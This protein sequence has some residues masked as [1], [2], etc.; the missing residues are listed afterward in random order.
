MFGVVNGSANKKTIFC[1]LN[2]IDTMSDI[3]GSQDGQCGLLHRVVWLKFNEVSEEFTAMIA[4]LMR[5]KSE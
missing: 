2:I 1:S 3:S 5:M 4:L